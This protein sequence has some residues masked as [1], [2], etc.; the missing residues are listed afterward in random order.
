MADLPYLYFLHIPKT[1]GTSVANVLHRV[2]GSDQILPAYNWQQLSQLPRDAMSRY[3]CII[4]HLGPLPYV[5]T[6]RQLTTITVLRDPIER[7]I[8][9]I[10]YVR[11]EIRAQTGNCL[12]HPVAKH[13]DL[14]LEELLRV[15]AVRASVSNTQTRWLGLRAD[16]SYVTDGADRSVVRRL[17]AQ[18]RELGDDELLVR[19]R[20]HLESMA[21][22]GVVHR[23][24][25]TMAAICALLGVPPPERTPRN[26]V[27][28]MSGSMTHRMRIGPKI[29]AELD[30]LNTHD[31]GLVGFAETLLAEKMADVEPSQTP[32]R[33]ITWRGRLK[34]LLRL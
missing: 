33:R 20:A 2:Y 9:H 6:D 34:R 3:R 18:V 26:N 11:Q 21:V 14:P 15:P 29:A 13:V 12:E 1:A 24:D 25:E 4:G 5:L 28:P 10:E 7:A 30:N 32:A 16:A 17:H 22:V 27:G 31:H 23:M 19:A 8:S